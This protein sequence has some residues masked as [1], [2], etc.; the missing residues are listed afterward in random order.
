MTGPALSVES[1]FASGGVRRRRSKMTRRSGRS[2]KMP[3]AVSSGSSASTVPT[4]TA[5]AS[6]C[7]RTQCAWR[8][9]AADVRKV[10]RPDV[11]AIR[12]SR[13][14]AA[15]RMTNGRPS[16]IKVK[17]GRLSDADA[18][19]PSPT[20]TCMPCSR[21]KANPRPLTIGFGSSV[22]ATTRLMPASRTRCTHGGVR[23]WCAHGSSV[24]YSVAPR[25]RPPASSSAFTS[26]CASPARW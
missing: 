7:A 23:P 20:S 16:R 22:A 3:R 10:R 6:T 12:P 18:S 2:R 15:F 17:K 21:R 5:M 26:A 4:P 13:L 25:A 19:A 14:A 11:S 1:T 9:A 24:Q 8:F